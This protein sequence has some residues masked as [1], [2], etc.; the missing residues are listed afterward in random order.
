MEAAFL[1]F[2]GAPRAGRYLKGDDLRA[3][4]PSEEGTYLSEG[5][6]L[7]RWGV[8]LLGGAASWWGG[9]LG[10]DKAGSP[11]QDS[12]GFGGPGPVGGAWLRRQG[13]PGAR[14]ISLVMG[15]QAPG[16]EG[17]GPAGQLCGSP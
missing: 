6:R 15:R 1:R 9:V 5:K 16:P 13:C 14:S 17:A 3:A 11:G 12:G 2:D 4:G 7:L 10:Q 8:P